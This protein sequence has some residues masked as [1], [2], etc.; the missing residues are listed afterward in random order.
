MTE[1]EENIEEKRIY[2][3]TQLRRNN[4][5][6]VNKKEGTKKPRPCDK[7]VTVIA[8]PDSCMKR[9][10]EWT[11]DNLLSPVEAFTPVCEK[12]DTASTIKRKRN[13]S[14][15]KPTAR[16][17]I[18]FEDEY[19]TSKETSD[20]ELMNPEEEK[21][22]E[23]GKHIL[24]I[25]HKN[26]ILK[27]NMLCSDVIN[28]AQTILKQQFPMINGFQHTGYAPIVKDGNWEYKLQMSPEI[29]PVA[30]IHHTG[31]QHWIASA[32]KRK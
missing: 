10:G 17:R 22:V 15:S 18:K 20:A 23:N 25:K 3:L 7:D 21:W 9:N 29:A 2:N 8:A 12:S 32:N 4:R 19:Q 14:H 27:D 5:K 1:L 6:R 13:D 26:D 24:T 28:F 31:Y 16:K 30:Q 11:D